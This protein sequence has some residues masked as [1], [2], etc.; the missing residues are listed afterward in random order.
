MRVNICPF[1]MFLSSNTSPPVPQ[2]LLPF[3]PPMPGG[4]APVISLSHSSE[5]PIPIVTGHP[6]VNSELQQVPA[7]QP[8]RG[9]VGSIRVRVHTC[10]EKQSVLA[11]Q[12]SAPGR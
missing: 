5:E 9:Y 6:H 4:C 2:D 10:I 3:N 8:Q 11:Q 12:I 7:L 1:S